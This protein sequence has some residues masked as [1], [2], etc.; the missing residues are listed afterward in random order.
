M[1]GIQGVMFRVTATLCCGVAIASAQAFAPTGTLKF[2]VGTVKPSVPGA[3]MT[4]IRPAPGGRRYSGTGVPLRS[5]L[6]IA[7][8]VKPEQIEGGPSWVDTEPFDL[9]AQAEHPSSI[10]DLHIML[11]NLLTEEFKLQFHYSRKEM[12][13][14]VLDV[15]KFGPKNMTPH[16]HPYGDNVLLDRYTEKLVHAT[17]KAHCASLDFLAWRLSQIFD[18]P[19][20]N[21]THIPGCF[22]FDLVFTRDLPPGYE[23]GEVFNGEPLDTSGPTVFQALRSQL[24]LRLE[25]KKAPVETLVIDSE[26]GPP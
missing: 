4:G 3:P 21:Q 8:Q 18:R 7:Y 16:P 11:Q 22:D 12:Q 1:G 5:M 15:D 24:G 20:I 6:W 23:E 26:R 13:A 10:E 2:E 19:V 9:N 14:Y 25:T 17:W